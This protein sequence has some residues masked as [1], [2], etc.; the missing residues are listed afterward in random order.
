MNRSERIVLI[1]LC[2]AVLGVYSWLS[3]VG[4]RPWR[5]GEPQRDHYNLL[6]S[7]FLK[8]QLSLDAPVH[9][10][11]LTLRNPYDPAQ[12]V[13]IPH[14]HDASLH[15]GRYY[16]YFGPAPAVTL[17]LPYRLL[18]GQMLPLGA[19]VTVFCAA[20][21]ACALWLLFLVRRDFFPRAGVAATASAR[22]R[23]G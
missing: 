2:L 17:L 3:V 11:L 4:S 14:I 6:V 18:T 21:F 15:R 8:G 19:A 22:L 23:P 7:G 10:D 9:P 20:G 12:R 13:G 16:I 5:F 1:A